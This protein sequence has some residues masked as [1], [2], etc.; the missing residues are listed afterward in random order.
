MSERMIPADKVNEILSNRNLGADEKITEIKAIL[1]TPK[2]PTMED[3]NREERE[4]CRWMQA[5]TTRGRALILGPEWVAEHAELLDQQGEVFYEDHANIAPR[6]DLPRFEWPAAEKETDPA[7][8]TYLDTDQGA[9][10]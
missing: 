8:L 1:H 5:D 10:Q 2:R 4:A 9:D 6:P 7:E 3:M